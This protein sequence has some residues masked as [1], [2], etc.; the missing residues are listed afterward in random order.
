MSSS[1]QKAR[2]SLGQTA[3]VVGAGIIG[4]LTARVLADYFD[5]VVILDKDEPQETNGPIFHARKSAPQGHHLHILLSGGAQIICDL[6]PG[7][8]QDFVQAGAQQIYFPRDIRWFLSNRWFP[9]H[10]GELRTFIQTRPLLEAVIRR[11]VIKLPNVTLKP[12]TRVIDY[13]LGA[14]RHTVTGVSVLDSDAVRRVL[15]AD[16]VA[17]AGGRGAL[18]T[19]WLERQTF[20][21][22]R[23][24]VMGIDLVYAT[25]FFDLPPDPGRDWK[26]L[27]CHPEAPHQKS[28]G[29][30]CSVENGHWHV[31]LAG[32][33]KD[34]P[35][36]DLEGFKAYA[37]R[38]PAPDFYEQI[39]DLTPIAPIRGYKFPASLRRHFDEMPDL[40]DRLVGIGDVIGS[41][42]PAFGQGM[43][44]G[45]IQVDAL[46][47]LLSSR[48]ERGGDLAGLQYPFYKQATKAIDPAWN[49]AG[50][51][52]LRD[53]L[54]TGHRP[55][56]FA[57]S[58]WYSNRLL[59]SPDNH[60]VQQFF[61][62]MHLVDPPSS[63]MTPDMIRRVLGL[64]KLTIDTARLPEPG[65]HSR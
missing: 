44:N 58:Q 13:R 4:L 10:R 49:M 33:H 32:Y 29:V 18:L 63:L 65:I 9:R 50:S 19:N 5:H 64:G 15:D 52:N 53:P 21:A 41:L 48:A 34:H 30:I 6:F 11:R 2:H 40:P 22:L 60:V 45:A 43:S 14:D 25:T 31:T 38:L 20:G 3:V 1:E 59:K 55:W 46:R 17:D 24:T 12:S 27:A 57:V 56:H 61:R 39:K 51:E 8:D 28:G 37:S 47:R 42:N 26:M 16:F 62:V 54:T 7:I 36:T 35:P 23:E